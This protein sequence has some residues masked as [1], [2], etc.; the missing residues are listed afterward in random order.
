MLDIF[1]LTYK[2]DYSEENFK[3][4]KEIACPGQTII[5][6]ADIEGIY[7]AHK[8]CALQSSTSHF[9]VVDGDAWIDDEFDFSYVPSTTDE[10]YPETCSAQCTHVWR[11]INPATRRAYGYGGVKLFAREAFFDKAWVHIKFP[12]V[13]VTS[14][15]ARRGFPYLPIQGISNETRFNSSSFNAWKGAFRECTKLASGVATEERRKKLK[16][17][18]DF[19]SSN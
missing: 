2:H 19:R 12:G 4:I 3:R 7:N 15:V 18:L 14:E 1:Y 13:D 8:E 10:V 17:I 16:A 9:F 11:A 6:V 5:H